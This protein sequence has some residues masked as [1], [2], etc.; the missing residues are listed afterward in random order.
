ML[1]Y[2]C[3]S[4]ALVPQKKVFVS[5]KGLFTELFLAKESFKEKL[6]IASSF[7]FCA[8]IAKTDFL[9]RDWHPSFLFL[10]LERTY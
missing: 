10:S 1:G 7:L 6:R 8:R 5:F 4:R 9:I 3:L 2:C